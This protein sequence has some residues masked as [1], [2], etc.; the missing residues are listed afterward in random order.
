MNGSRDFGAR[1]YALI[2]AHARGIECAAKLSTTDQ[3]PFRYRQHVIR[4]LSLQRKSKR[5]ACPERLRQPISGLHPGV[6]EIRRREGVGFGYLGAER[7]E[8]AVDGKRDLVA[9]MVRV[10]DR[11]RRARLYRADPLPANAILRLIVCIHVV[12]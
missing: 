6:V 7:V 4:L 8:T 11:Q 1:T 12:S 5:P 2:T 9:T 3:E 10:D